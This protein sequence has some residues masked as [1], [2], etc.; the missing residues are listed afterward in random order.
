MRYIASYTNALQINPD[1][2]EAH[3]NLG[4][5]FKALGK[6]EEAIASYTKALQIRPD[7]TG[8]HYNLGIILSD[9]GKYEESIASYTKVLQFQPDFAEA[10]GLIGNAFVEVDKYEEAIASFT[11]ALQFKPDYAEVKGKK[12]FQQARICD[13]VSLEIQGS[14]QEAFLA[15]HGTTGTAVT[16]FSCLSLEDHPERHLKR[17]ECYAAQFFNHAV[18][19]DF[20]RPQVKP[21]QIR[22]GY[23]S[24]DF[25]D[26][27]TMYLMARAFELHDNAQFSIHAY[28]YGP[29]KS[30]A[31]RSRLRDAVDVFHDVR[32]LEDKEVAQLARNESIDIAID[33]KDYT[34]NTRSAIFAYQAAPI[35]VNYL[36]YPG[37]MG[38]PF[39]D[40][41]VA[42]KTLIPEA[43]QKFYSEKVVY[44][45]AQLSGERRYEAHCR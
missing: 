23:F 13:W 1:F 20:T 29:D 17:S 19:P 45:P 22:I 37:T 36:G 30:D 14:N 18:L 44:L 41:I 35:Q 28:S 26:H 10:H 32:Q 27:A 33:L 6:P 40:Y 38:A 7:L 16:P 25:H 3:T 8:A 42:D 2:A 24:A 21:R 9:L 4:S 5:T 31:M 34:K 12:I 11:K 15:A 43:S 39:M